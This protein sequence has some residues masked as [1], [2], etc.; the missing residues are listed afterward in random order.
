MFYISWAYF[1]F[2][3]VPRGSTVVF[4]KRYSSLSLR[5]PERHPETR[6]AAGNERGLSVIFAWFDLSWFNSSDS[7][8]NHK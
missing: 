4:M 3:A 6:V 2:S 1:Y 7:P 5:I 8:R